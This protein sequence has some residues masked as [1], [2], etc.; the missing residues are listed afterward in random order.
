MFC[1]LAGTP[2]PADLTEPGETS[3]D[4]ATD[5]AESLDRERRASALYAEFATSAVTPRLA[6]VWAAVS[7]VER[8]HIDFDGLA[9]TYV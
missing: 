5:I 7:D 6:E 3:G 4:W 1:K 9:R 2:K 8:D